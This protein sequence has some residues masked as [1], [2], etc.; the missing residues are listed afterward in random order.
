MQIPGLARPHALNAERGAAG[1]I[2]GIAAVALASTM[3]MQGWIKAPVIVAPIGASAVLA[4][5]VPASPL[6][7]PRAII[8]GNVCSALVGIGVAKLVAQ[9][10]AAM[11]LAVGLAIWVM[12]RLRCLHPPGGAV[13]LVAVTGGP[14]VREAGFSFAL[15]PVAINSLVLVGAAVLFNN[16]TG[17]RYPHRPE[18]LP[19]HAGPFPLAYRRADLD[20]VL[21]ELG[22]APDVDPDDLDSIIRAVESR[23]AARGGAG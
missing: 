16:L 7:Q 15:A 19:E 13:A 11:A 10:V 18:A 2:P 23:I 5:A 21:H 1:A 14:L 4:F 9:P 17:H 12:H 3:V 8:G 6:A 22:D 20:A